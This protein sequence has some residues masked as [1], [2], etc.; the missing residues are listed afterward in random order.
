MQMT[1]KSTTKKLP[2]AA[3]VWT[4]KTPEGLPAPGVLLLIRSVQED[5]DGEHVVVFIDTGCYSKELE[6]FLTIDNVAIEASASITHYA[7][8]NGMDGKPIYL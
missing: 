1:V 8:V 3:T 4:E 5:E 2:V 7:I 6:C